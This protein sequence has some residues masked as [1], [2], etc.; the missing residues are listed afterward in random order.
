[1]TPEKHIKHGNE[2]PFDE[3]QEWWNDSGRKAS[4]PKDRAHSGARGIVAALQARQG[5]KHEL[6]QQK[7]DEETRR[8]IV[9]EL[10]AIIREASAHR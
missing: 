7:I 8:E 3:S 4:K 2:F 1:M 5:I 9:D 6:S 10:A